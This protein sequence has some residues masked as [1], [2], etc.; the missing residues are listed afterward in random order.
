[1]EYIPRRGD[2]CGR[3]A[4]RKRDDRKGRP[5]TIVS[6]IGGV[7]DAEKAGAVLKLHHVPKL[8]GIIFL[9]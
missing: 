8:I 6:F 7:F 9:L 4:I 2:P 5:Y 3:P 1:M